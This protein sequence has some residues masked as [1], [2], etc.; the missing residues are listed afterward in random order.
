MLVLEHPPPLGLCNE[1]AQIT[2]HKPQ[3]GAAVSQPSRM[4]TVKLSFAP[5]CE[6]WNDFQEEKLKIP[7]LSSL[8]LWLG[9]CYQF[10]PE[11]TQH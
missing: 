1:G 3:E 8:Q 11:I 4:E 9:P 5:C 2:L 6:N 10:Y 7:P